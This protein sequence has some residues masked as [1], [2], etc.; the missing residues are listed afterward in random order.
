MCLVYCVLVTEEGRM[1]RFD[2]GGR[3]TGTMVSR[4]NILSLP[5]VNP[6]LERMFPA[7]QKRKGTPD[8]KP[9]TEVYPLPFYAARG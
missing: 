8:P 2:E 9:K 4:D 6:F 1:I 5:L 7:Q 3:G